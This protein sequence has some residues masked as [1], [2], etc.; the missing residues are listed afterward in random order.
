[1]FNDR[2]NGTTHFFGDSCNPPHKCP[3]GTCV[4]AYNNVCK[5]CNTYM[6]TED[7]DEEL[8]K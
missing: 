5:V 6:G 2:P 1:M 3:N 8:I 7:K 4:R